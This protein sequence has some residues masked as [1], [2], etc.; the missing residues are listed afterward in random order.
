MSEF[1]AGQDPTLPVLEKFADML[2]CTTE[3]LL[4]RSFQNAD[5]SDELFRAATSRMA[6]DVFDADRDVKDDHKIRCRRV[7]GHA[8]API[9]AQGWGILAEQI[10][11]AI[12]PTNGGT[13]L[14]V[15][16]GGNG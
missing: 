14:H 9:T 11:L 13:S 6:F 4:H 7:V 8:A 15:V 3:F 5:D 2:E 12:G 16:R 10:E 1:E